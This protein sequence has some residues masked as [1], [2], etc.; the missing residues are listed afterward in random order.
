M[1]VEV[2]SLKR[3]NELAIRVNSALVDGSLPEPRVVDE[4]GEF[5]L[6]F[7]LESE[8]L[9]VLLKR[10]RNHNGFANIFVLRDNDS[11]ALIS[12]VPTSDALREHL[13][14]D[15]TGA[16]QPS[17]QSSV[18]VFLDYLI[19]HGEGVLIPSAIVRKDSEQTGARFALKP[20]T[21]SA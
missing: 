8:R 10:V 6:V 11:V 12:A 18:G 13:A 14:D 4:N 16:E 15:M 1:T 20:E 19:A 9:A 17:A 2:S 3:L 21:V 5:P 7:A